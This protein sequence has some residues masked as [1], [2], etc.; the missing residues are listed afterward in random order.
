[1]SRVS[2]PLLA[3]MSSAGAVVDEDE[4]YSEVLNEKGMNAE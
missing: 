2:A 1:M 3:A 4:D